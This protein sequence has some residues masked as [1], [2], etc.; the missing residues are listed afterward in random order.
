[1]PASAEQVREQLAD[2]IKNLAAGLNESIKTLTTSVNDLRSEFVAFK[3]S[4][5]TKL[6]VIQGIGRWVAGGFIGGVV[7][8]AISA[9]GIIWA[10]S[11]LNSK[12]EQQGSDLKEIKQRLDQIVAKPKP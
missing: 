5:E 7:A 2:E 9:A 4:T 1:M 6:D 11:A 12:V 10:A 8:I 3:A